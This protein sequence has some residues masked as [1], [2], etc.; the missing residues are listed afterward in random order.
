[1]NKSLKDRIILIKTIQS[2]ANNLHN[3]SV[4]TATEFDTVLN[5]V[6]KIRENKQEF[7][8]LSTSGGDSVS[9][10]SFK[11][12]AKRRVKTTF[13]R[14]VRRRLNIKDSEISHKVLDKLS[15]EIKKILSINDLDKQITVVNGSDIINEYRNAKAGSCMTG[16]ECDKVQIYALNKDK[17]WL[18][19]H[20]KARAILWK[21]DEGE[22]VLDRVYPAQCHSVEIIRKW[23][24][25]KGYVLRKNP[26]RVIETGL[27]AELSD[28]KIHSVTLKHRNIFPY[29]D[30]FSFGKCNPKEEKIIVVKN[31]PKFGNMILHNTQ[32]SYERAKV[33]YKCECKVNNGEHIVGSD[34]NLYCYTCYD[35]M[36]FLCDYC[37]N[38]KV[39]EDGKNILSSGYCLCN[40]CIKYAEKC[41]GCGCREYSINM[42][43][44]SVD[45]YYCYECYVE[46]LFGCSKCKKR[47]PK[48]YFAIND[49]CIDCFD[50]EICFNC[51]K[52]IL[53]KERILI[54]KNGNTICFECGE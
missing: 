17:V 48:K 32:G 38:D 12:D 54:N 42:S 3:S 8:S 28:N 21:T 14:Y 16:C 22:Y 20:D 25:L 33:C 53:P 35:T 19:L 39:I 13:G 36:F 2:A 30:T 23:A 4:I 37:G 49:I 34:N 51:N 24:E 5:I 45:E 50:G 26:D 43:K 27:K 6:N 46:K 7:L 29:M 1:M 11:K 15:A 40:N 52:K 18:V 41:K 44:I 31:D 47:Y 9:Y 10:Y